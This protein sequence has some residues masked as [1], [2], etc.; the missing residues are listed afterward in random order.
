MSSLKKLNLT[1]KSSFDVKSKVADFIASWQKFYPKASSEVLGFI[2][3]FVY[4]Q[5]S[6][7]P[8]ASE[9]IQNQFMNGYCYHF[10]VM[11][12]HIFGRGTVC[13]AAP[14][15]HIVWIDGDWFSGVPYDV[16]GVNESDCEVYI[17]VEELGDGLEDF[18]HIPGKEAFCDDKQISEILEKYKRLSLLKGNCL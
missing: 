16:C 6:E 13:I 2:G 3:R 11:M 9:I 1:G 18:M 12:K 10:A 14:I 17:P 4:A 15:G 8:E 7:A 5:G